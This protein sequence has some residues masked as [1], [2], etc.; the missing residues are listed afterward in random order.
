MGKKWVR[1]T[2][3]ASDSA[4]LHWHWAHYLARS[5]V[6]PRRSG[7]FNVAFFTCQ[8]D[9]MYRLCNHNQIDLWNTKEPTYRL[10]SMHV[11]SIRLEKSVHYNTS[12]SDHSTLQ[13]SLITFPLQ[14]YFPR[15]V[16]CLASRRPLAQRFSPPRPHSISLQVSVLV[17]GLKLW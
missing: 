14:P 3:H 2:T 11:L 10:S 15:L 5:D 13:W 17:L 7:M 1:W 6:K 16:L 9:F 4:T 12:I 8:A